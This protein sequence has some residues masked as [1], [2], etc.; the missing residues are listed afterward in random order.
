MSKALVAYY[1]RAGENYVSGTLKKLPIGNTEAAAD[2]ITKITGADT[3]RIEQVI[4]YS[5]SYNTCTAQ[6]KDDQQNGVRP[7]LKNFPDSLDDCDVIYLG[8]PNYWNTMPMAVFTFLEHFDFTGKTIMP[9]C[10]HEGSGMGKSEADIK[11]LCPTANVKRGL[12]VYGSRVGMAEK[13]IER[14]IKKI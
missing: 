10:T 12:A 14:W 8:Y 1:S 2:I 11:K 13:D 4:P 3:F 7:Q 6:A 9:F 5:E